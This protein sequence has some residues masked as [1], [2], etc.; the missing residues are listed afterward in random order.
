MPFEN[1]CYTF[2]LKI[3]CDWQMFILLQSNKFCHCFVCI[4][5]F[6][7][8]FYYYCCTSQLNM[9]YYWQAPL[10]RQ[11]VGFSILFLLFFSPSFRLEAATAE[12]IFWVFLLF[13]CRRVQSRPISHLGLLLQ[14]SSVSSVS[15]CVHCSQNVLLNTNW[16][17]QRLQC[18]S[19]AVAV[20][21]AAL[22]DWLPRHCDL[23]QR[24]QTHYQHHRQAIRRHRLC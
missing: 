6:C 12:T 11:W 15:A 2:K 4:F 20:A 1:C 19:G 24:Q 10:G 23:H 9:V 13:S 18:F 7:A 17:D 16:N 5:S 22:V 3:V 21:F 8:H 14:P